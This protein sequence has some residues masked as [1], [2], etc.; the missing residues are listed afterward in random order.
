MSS[1]VA[2]MVAS[3]GFSLVRMMILNRRRA[4]WHTSDRALVSFAKVRHDGH[5]RGRGADD[6]C[7]RG[8]CERIPD[9]SERGTD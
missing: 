3:T 9:A 5:G 4:L 7:E 1:R 2:C 8:A 6:A